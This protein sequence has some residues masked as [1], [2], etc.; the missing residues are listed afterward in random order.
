MAGPQAILLLDV[1]I[2]YAQ[3]LT[4]WCEERGL[5]G[6]QGVLG[7]AAVPLQAPVAVCV[8]E[9]DGAGDALRGIAATRKFLRD[10]PVLVLARR[11]S[12]AFAVEMM[13]RGISLLPLPQDP[14]DVAAR[15]FHLL[16]S[17]QRRDAPDVFGTT[18][19]RMQ[20][21]IDGV[22]RVSRLRRPVLILGER[23]TGKEFLARTI[24]R[25]SGKRSP[26]AS[27]DCR[28]SVLSLPPNIRGTLYLENV[29]ALSAD[30]QI[31]VL[32]L[33]RQPSV[34]L[35]ASS[36]GGLEAAVGHGRFDAAL[37]MRLS[38]HALEVPPLRERRQDI[39][40]IVR[41][42]LDRLAELLNLPTPSAARSFYEQ[43]CTYEWPGNIDELIG[44]LERVMLRR[45]GH[46]PLDRADLQGINAPPT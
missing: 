8:I 30:L 40:A 38:T 1:S 18:D 32:E 6:L 46:R 20:D 35:L 11:T 5:V 15:A 16:G 33:A 19:A 25:L 4:R 14:W 45:A 7:S 44:V 27:W 37:F 23:G 13:K 36:S 34:R 12:V 43:M 17:S 31:A 22:V 41:A 10:C 3:P 9:T 39:A 26:F 29:E 28:D 24:H 21:A 2:R 42:E